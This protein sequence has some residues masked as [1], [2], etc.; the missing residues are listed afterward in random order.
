MPSFAM[1]GDV[2]HVVRVGPGSPALVDRTGTAK[3]ATTDPAHRIICVS[4]ATPP[5][6][7]PNVVAHEA[8]HAVMVSYGMLPEVR[9]FSRDR[10]AAEE[11]ACS[12]MADHAA[13]VLRATRAV[14]SGAKRC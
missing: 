5:R 1:N 13:E 6:I 14:L 10:V 12:L 8:T 7:L 3:L 4:S 9:A 11:W 2:W